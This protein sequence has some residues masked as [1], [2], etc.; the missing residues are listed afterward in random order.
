MNVTWSKRSL[1]LPKM[2][3]I[4]ICKSFL[5]LFAVA[6]VVVAVVVVGFCFSFF[7]LEN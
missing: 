6:V 3:S 1:V 4:L 5:I 2:V 7:F